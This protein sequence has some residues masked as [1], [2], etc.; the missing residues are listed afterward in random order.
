M[1]V[2]RRVGQ[3]MKVGRRVGRH[4]KVGWRSCEELFVTKKAGPLCMQRSFGVKLRNF[5]LRH[6][7]DNCALIGLAVSQEHLVRNPGFFVY[8]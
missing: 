7:P 3:H 4:M 5:K 8:H 6:P 2:G 1:K